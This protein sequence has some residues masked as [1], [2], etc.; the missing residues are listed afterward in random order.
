[1]ADMKTETEMKVGILQFYSDKNLR[2]KYGVD[3]T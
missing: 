1:M 3:A 2:G